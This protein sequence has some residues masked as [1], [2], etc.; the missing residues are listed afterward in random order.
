MKEL[1]TLLVLC[2]FSNFVSGQFIPIE[3]HGVHIN[4]DQLKE[5]AGWSQYADKEG[6]MV[7]NSIQG[8]DA[9]FQKK[10]SEGVQFSFG[11]KNPTYSFYKSVLFDISKDF[12]AV[13]NDL[14]IGEVDNMTPDQLDKSIKRGL[15]SIDKTFITRGTYVSIEWNN[16]SFYVKFSTPKI[17]KLIT[18]LSQ[19]IF[20]GVK[21]DSTKYDRKEWTKI[22]NELRHKSE[23]SSPFEYIALDTTNQDASIY[24]FYSGFAGLHLI[25]ST[26]LELK[27]QSGHNFDYNFLHE[28][29]WL[30]ELLTGKEISDMWLDVENELLI[31]FS[32]EKLKL[33]ILFIHTNTEIY[34]KA[35]KR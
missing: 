26:Y 21:I 31:T 20:Y 24:M 35:I 23:Y 33:S 9:V 29:D 15:V 2:C 30:A 4:S 3:F 34:K 8:F 22:D 13:K 11:K 27:N 7:S 16:E 19:R 1:L 12:G 5:D 32:V 6:Y 28:E 18:N 25:K 17:D 14:S 10:S